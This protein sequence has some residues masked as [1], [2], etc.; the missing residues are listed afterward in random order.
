MNQN[1]PLLALLTLIVALLVL[2]GYL[3]KRQDD[4]VHRVETSLLD[5]RQSMAEMRNRV[6][7][8]APPGGQGAPMGPGPGGMQGGAPGG[9]GKATNQFPPGI[10]PDAEQH[11][12][13]GKNGGGQGTAMAPSP[14]G[15][16]GPAS[17][18]GR[19]PAVPSSPGTGAQAVGSPMANLLARL[20]VLEYRADMAL[21]DAQTEEIKKVL[22]RYKA[23]EVELTAL[24]KAVMNA[25]NAK[26]RGYL[27]TETGQVATKTRELSDISGKDD[28]AYA[29]LALEFLDK[30]I[31]PAGAASP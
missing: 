18:A 17:P 8:F 5:L 11:K 2:H 9:P 6:P 7:G 26:Q 14:G 15:P 21:T 24:D 30:P 3:L 13:K 29:D 25:L 4:S 12:G 28:H 23:H 1:R 16:Q 27:T 10:S 22:T 19:P 20:I 31:R